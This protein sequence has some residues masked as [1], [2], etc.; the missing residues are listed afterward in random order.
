MGK[1]FAFVPRPSFPESPILEA[2]VRRRGACLAIPPE[3]FGALEWVDEAAAMA[4]VSAVSVAPA[5]GADAVAQAIL[6]V[7][8]GH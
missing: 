6:E 8:I 5:G 1:P 7:A 2:Y 3:R 4:A